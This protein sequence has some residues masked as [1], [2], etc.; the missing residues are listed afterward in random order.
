MVGRLIGLLQYIATS[1]YN[2]L[3]L[4]DTEA[5]LADDEGS[6]WFAGSAFCLWAHLVVV[7]L[8]TGGCSNC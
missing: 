3:Q 7:G 6:S 8:I 2:P 5:W 1:R 4:V